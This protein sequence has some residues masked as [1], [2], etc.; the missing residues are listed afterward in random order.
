[1]TV[2]AFG[3]SFWGDENILTLIF[4][5]VVVQLCEYTKSLSTGY[6]TWYLY[7]ISLHI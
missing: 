1:M 3:V 5:M 2:K 4:V 7:V 6:F